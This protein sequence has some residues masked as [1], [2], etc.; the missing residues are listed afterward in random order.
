M[1]GTPEQANNF[2]FEL[3]F[4]KYLL[5]K[6][7]RGGGG[8]RGEGGPL[9]AVLTSLLLSEQFCSGPNLQASWSKTKL[10][11]LTGPYLEFSNHLSVLKL[12]FG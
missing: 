6:Y 11:Q 4:S 9:V 3:M 12:T 10:L 8:R 2:P 5:F 1:C 7:L